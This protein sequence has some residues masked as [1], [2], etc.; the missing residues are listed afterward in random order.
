[1]KQRITS[2]RRLTTK[3]R[4]LAKPQ[5]NAASQ[6][7]SRAAAESINPN[8]P[9]P[10]VIQTWH[11]VDG[12][13]IHCIETG[14]DSPH[15]PVVLMHGLGDSHMTWR[16]IVP[17]LARDRRVII[18]DLPGHGLSER[19]DVS[20]RLEWYSHIM[21]NWLL[22]LGLPSVDVIGHS[23]GGGIAQM[24]LLECR[25]RIRRLGLLAAGGLGREISPVLRIASVP[26]VVERLGQPFMQLGTELFLRIAQD[27]RPV[28]DIAALGQMNRLPGTARAFARTV[29]D[30]M[31]LR[32]QRHSF[33][34]RAHEVADLPPI[35]VYW[36]N[37]DSIIPVA[38]GQHLVRRVS[39]VQLVIFDECGH[40][41]HQEQPFVAAQT[42][43]DFLNEPNPPKARYLGENFRI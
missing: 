38:H 6:R 34:Q 16:K 8:A 9:H 22:G 25:Q 21:T 27:G 12:L 24:M 35:R 15:T 23:L 30:L 3:F 40:F 17:E 31:D 32:A 20:Y 41:P 36:G 5:A 43:K 29:R 4:Y 37:R 39:G 33:Y 2:I 13:R 26:H 11:K 10:P 14:I 28:E 1:M 18:P 42:L 19:P 7:Y